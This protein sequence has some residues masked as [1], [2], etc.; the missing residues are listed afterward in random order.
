AG[1]TGMDV[2][3]LLKKMRQDVVDYH[4]EVNGVRADTH[5]RIYTSI[6]VVHVIRGRD[7]DPAALERAVSLSAEKYCSVGAMLKGRTDVRHRAIVHQ[8]S[9]EPAA[10]LSTGAAGANPARA[11]IRGVTRR[12]RNN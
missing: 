1:C 7:I 2:I 12:R 11:A 8:A 9:D 10:P 6:E 4:I 5:P 3:S